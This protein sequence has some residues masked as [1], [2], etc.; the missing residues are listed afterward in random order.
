VESGRF[1]VERNAKRPADN[2]Q[3]DEAGKSERAP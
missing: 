3:T 2:N 1:S